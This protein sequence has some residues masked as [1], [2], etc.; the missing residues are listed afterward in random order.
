MK[1]RKIFCLI[2]LAMLAATLP[3]QAAAPP[4]GSDRLRELVV[5]PQMN[6]SFDFGI[7]F[8]CGE[9][10]V[11]KT[12]DPEVQISGLRAELKQHPDDIGRLLHL[13]YLLDDRGETNAAKVYYQQ[14]E[15]LCQKRLAAK[16][17]DGLALTE[18]GRALWQLDENGAAENA[19]RKS[20]LVSSNEW[21]CWVR[22]GNF[23]ANEPFDTM[24]PKKLSG[25]F[26]P[27]PRQPPQQ[28]LDY[29]PSPEAL[30]RAEAA[31]DQASRCFDHA[32]ALAPKEP[33]VFLQRAGFISVSNWQSCLFRHFRTGEEIPS[34]RWSSAF[35]SPETCANLR[36]VAQLDDRNYEFIS[37]AAYFE[38]FRAMIQANWPANFTVKMMPEES[39]QS[40]RNAM[41]RL[42]VL[43]KNS[44]TKLAVG[45]L[46]NLGVLN[47]TFGDHAAASDDFKRAVALDPA[48]ETSWDML[49]ATM[50]SQ[51]VSPEEL[52][53]VCQSRLNHKN[54][55]RN[56]LLLAKCL[57]RSGKWTDA[58]AQAIAAGRLETN[59][60]ISPMLI[61][62][63]ALKQS[64]Q[65][66]Y[67][68]IAGANLIRAGEIL[69]RIPE[70]E[71]QRER[72][73]ELGLNM[74][75]LYVLDHHPDMARSTANDYLKFFPDSDAAKEILRN[76]I[77][78]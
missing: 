44:D 33:E 30:K 73:R 49:L 10:V 26:A 58:T 48:N 20:V 11:N 52:V 74:I 63:I 66:N 25:Q 14:A 60:I 53:T 56:H 42:D 57:V 32:M 16:P 47:V 76:L 59:N 55:A 21:R 37:L 7:A 69:E 24:F 62:A 43:S 71:E 46:V 39:R 31:C 77:E 34:L 9:W 23:L 41:T 15:Q 38:W 5:Y 67:L 45:A 78:N 27:S 29:R 51:N 6:L 2:M 35:F 75:I 36:K 13:G 54:S 72:T 4:R 65:T 19:Y 17:Q 8:Q 50:L 68:P 3:A 61:A 40:I 70:G 22:L 64:A 1:I 12:T 28:V 18:L